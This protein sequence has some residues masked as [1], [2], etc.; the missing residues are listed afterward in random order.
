[1]GYQTNK[2]TI[3]VT[4]SRAI[5]VVA[6]GEYNIYVKELVES[7]HEFFKG[8]VYLFTDQPDSYA[9]YTDITLIDTPHIGFPA[10]PLLRFELFKQHLDIF[11]EE[12]IYLMDADVKFVKTIDSI[13]SNRVACL[14]R[15]IMRLRKD[16]NYE[17][18]PSSDAYVAEYE[19]EKYYHCAW[20]GG[21]EWTEMVR[22]VAEQ[23]EHDVNVGIRAIWGDESHINRYFIDNPPTQVLPPNFMTPENNQYFIPFVKHQQKPFKSVYLGDVQELREINPTEYHD[24]YNRIRR[25]H[26]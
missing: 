2:Q 18:N 1:M 12:Y 22:T 7:C 6:T 17:N 4:P 8:H 9:D 23:I 20:C 14:H 25:L 5:A 15:N 3:N 13:F 10:M 26:R 24:L 11:Q 16:F 21:S 19:G